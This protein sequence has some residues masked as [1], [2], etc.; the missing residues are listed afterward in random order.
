MKQLAIILLSAFVLFATG[1]TL[2]AGPGDE[3]KAEKK[4]E[5]RHHVLYFDGDELVIPELD[6]HYVDDMLDDLDYE[7]GDLDLQL[8]DLHYRLSELD[9]LDIHV[10][11]I[12]INLDLDHALD[13]LQEHLAVL[14]E[15]DFDLSDCD[16]DGHRVYAAGEG[17]MFRDL[18]ES[19][20]LRLE[21]LRSLARQD[22]DTAIPALSRIAREDE[23][24]A[25]RYEAVRKLGRFID[26]QRVVQV[27]AQ[28]IEKDQ[29]LKV[30]KKAIQVL[31]RSS[32]PQAVKILEDLLK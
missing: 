19:E 22:A 29:H 2:A 7:L 17:G 18:S 11:E 32:D 13:N 30:R 21:A 1:N 27:L 9:D 20:Q 31:S 14:P 3:K 25:L 15:I 26:D 10:P 16:F 23:S 24:P 28:V 12:D 5:R 4:K 8:G 6:D